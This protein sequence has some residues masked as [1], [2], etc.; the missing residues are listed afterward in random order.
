VA[1]WSDAIGVV[2]DLADELGVAIEVGAAI[3]APWHP[4]RCAAV[5]I[6]TRVIG[7]A[8]E[9]HPRVVG[10]LGLPPATAAFEIDLDALLAAVP[11]VTPAPAFSTMPVAKED[12]AVVVAADVPAEAVRRALLDGGGELVESIRLFDR[13]AG[14]QV[15]PGRQSLAFALRLRA[16]DRTLSAAEVATVREGALAAA[17][18]EV[19]AVLRA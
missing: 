14:E 1:S 2:R 16:P 6:G 12:I 15:G 3:Q 13:Y 18:A 9:L 7:H 11:P 4:G 19:G 8:G 5:S 17:H 10:D